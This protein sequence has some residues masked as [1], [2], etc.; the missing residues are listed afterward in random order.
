MINFFRTKFSLLDIHTKE[1]IKK[2]SASTIVKVAGIIISLVVSIF[3]GRVLGA[4][5]LGVI[6]LADR[7]VRLLIILS[8]IGFGKVLIKEVARAYNNKNW[9]HIGNVMYTAFI[10]NHTTKVYH[11]LLLPWCQKI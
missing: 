4:E 9:V 1:V 3:L 2:S 7:I 8:L 6:N 5:G 10:I 11:Y